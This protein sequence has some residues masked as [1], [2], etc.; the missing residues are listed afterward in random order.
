MTFV[1]HVIFMQH[2]TFEH[3]GYGFKTAMRMGWKAGNIIISTAASEFVEHQEGVKA[4]MLVLTQAALYANT[5]TI[6][7]VAALQNL[8]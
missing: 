5:S 6:A 8:L 7:G 1:A 4:R 2:V 3:I